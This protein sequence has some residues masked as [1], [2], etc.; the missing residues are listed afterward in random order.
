MTCF[1]YG[2]IVIRKYQFD[3]P[4]SCVAKTKITDL[5]SIKVSQNSPW[6]N[7]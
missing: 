7:S 4:H 1:K 5:D 3:F 2:T 6:V